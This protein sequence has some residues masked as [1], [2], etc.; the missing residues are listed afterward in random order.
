MMKL[1]ILPCAEKL[2][3]VLS[4]ALMVGSRIK[5]GREFQT[6]GPARPEGHKCWAGSICDSYTS[7]FTYDILTCH[8]D[9]CYLWWC[10]TAVE[11]LYFA[12]YL[13]FQ[14]I[15]HVLY[16]KMTSLIVIQ[17]Q[18][19]C[20]Q[21]LCTNICLLFCEIRERELSKI[22]LW[23]FLWQPWPIAELAE[24]IWIEKVMH[25]LKTVGLSL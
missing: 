12:L 10:Y 4:T 2:E 1:P 25:C 22:V 23:Q 3:L 8:W 18:H 5:S 6:V 21:S 7:C 16:S 9:S 20:H 15:S 14:T 17:C 11:L 19:N 24:R 13:Q